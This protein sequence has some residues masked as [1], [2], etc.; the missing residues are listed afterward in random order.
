MSLIM[1]SYLAP[2]SSYT[3]NRLI[4]PV[5]VITALEDWEG[6]KKEW[7][8]FCEKIL[9]TSAATWGSAVIPGTFCNHDREFSGMAPKLF[10]FL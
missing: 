4:Y 7:D 3:K 10:H 5:L 6:R 1:S 2:Y 9:A 8:T